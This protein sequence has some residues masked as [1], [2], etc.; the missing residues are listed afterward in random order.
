MGGP[1][2]GP[3]VSGGCHRHRPRYPSSVIF[4]LSLCSSRKEGAGT[5]L[6]ICS[7]QKRHSSTPRLPFTHYKRGVC[8]SVCSSH[9][10]V[11]CGQGSR[12]GGPSE[13]PRPSIHPMWMR[14]AVWSQTVSSASQTK[15]HKAR[16]VGQT[17]LGSA[18]RT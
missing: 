11:D 15:V 1:K 4:L 2:Q 7:E 12:C 17:G 10:F 8:L 6:C 18:H 3:C 14:D 9:T 5:L 13:V 16:W